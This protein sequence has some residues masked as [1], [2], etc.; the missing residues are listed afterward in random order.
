M[1]VSASVLY[2]LQLFFFFILPRLSACVVIV[3]VVVSLFACFF[4]VAF[5]PI[6][7]VNL[8]FAHKCKKRNAL[9]PTHTHTQCI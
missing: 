3:V 8:I 2:L 4:F 5:Q 6:V 1:C 7:L 9:T